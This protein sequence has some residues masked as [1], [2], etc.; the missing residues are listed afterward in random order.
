MRPEHW[1]YTIPLRLRSLFRWAQADQ[2]LDDELREHLARK[3]EEYVAQGMTQEEAHRRARLDLGGIEQTKEQCR[4][5]RRVNW[6]QDFVQDLRFGTRT[7]RKSP[8][9]TIVAVLT[10][11]LGIGANTAIFSI[12]NAVLLRNLPVKNPKELVLLGTGRGQGSTGGVDDVLYSYRFYEELAKRNQ[13]FSET[14]AMMSVLFDGM[15]GRVEGSASLEPMNVQLVSGTY[16]SMLGVEPILGR[17]F[18]KLDDEP[19]GAQ[20][21]AMISYSWWTRR[22]ARDPAVI[23]KTIAI[24]PT[25]Y[26]IVGVTA[27]NFSGTTVGESPDVWIPLSMQKQVS[28]GWNGLEDRWWDSLYILARLKP[29]VSVAQAEAGINVLAK[30]IWRDFAGPVIPPHRQ[31]NIDEAW[32]PLTSAARGL[33]ELREYS[34]PLQILL[35]VVALVLLIAC[36]NIAN[37]LLA[38]TANRQREIAVRTAVGAGRARVFRQLLT[39]SLLLACLGGVLGLLF[40]SWASR[41]ILVWI[42]AGPES[43]PLNIA[44]D[45]RLLA[46]TFLISLVTALLFGTLPALRSTHVNLTDAF[47]SGRGAAALGV[48]S[49]FSSALIVSQVA[50]SFVLLIGAGLFLRTL[51]NLTH[52]NTGFD[53]K[54]VLLFAIDPPAVGYKV[55]S[56]LVN[57]YQQLEQRVAAEP[58]VL[59]DSVSL[60]T[61]NQGGWS[62]SV[63]VLGGGPSLSDNPNVMHNAVG[64]GYFATM[65]IP[66]LTG[67]VFGPQDTATSAKVAVINQTMARLY[68]PDGSPIGRRFGIEGDPAYA[69]DFEI[70]GVVKDAKYE[71]LGESPEPGAY[72]LYSQILHQ[73]YY[74]FE[75][76][77]SGDPRP[78]IA[79]V[80][81]TAASVDPNLPV[82]YQSTLAEQVGRSVASQSLTARLSAFFGLLAVFLASIGIYGLTSYGVARR[83]NEIGIRVALGAPRARVFW[84]ILR[85]VLLFASTGLALGVPIALAVGQLVSSL[86]FGVK[87]ADPATMVVTAT[88]LLV[89][90]VAAGYLPARRAMRVDP[91]VALRYE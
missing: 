13:V 46:F 89:L 16:F 4:D 66:L 41:A 59:A 79:E 43:L 34:L 62:T 76:R 5:A 52:V 39:E 67:R 17:E 77:Y 35:V 47:K 54:S 63:S 51:V 81:S 7:L 86:L 90:N 19:L 31:R 21:I 36:A 22:F 80:R 70:I 33:S 11:A 28:P 3:T 2:E 84:I 64:R 1:L 40:A 53:E 73:F 71:S 23:G 69:A 91:M 85:D 25:L 50:L 82:V 42:S 29:G 14:S 57:L 37:L 30:A 15:H 8:G 72:Y 56:R 26:S 58:G 60:L 45:V 12:L 10:L 78:I 38:R 74:D 9:F 49:R 27:G 6:I 83:T 65:G 24:G 75:V 88:L 32:I 18:T 48:R 44:P 61:F 55:D 20:A 68:F 87:P